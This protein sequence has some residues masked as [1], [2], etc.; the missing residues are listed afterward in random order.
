[1]TLYATTIDFIPADSPAADGIKPV[2]PIWMDVDNG[3]VH[4]VFDIW[5]GSGG[6]GRQV[7]LPG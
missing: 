1:M 5:K 2:T 3:S 4:P 6:K 7:H